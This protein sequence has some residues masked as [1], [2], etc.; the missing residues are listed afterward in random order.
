MD[1][2]Q[3]ESCHRRAVV[4]QNDASC[5]SSSRRPLLAE[6]Y[7]SYS[8]A[9]S[10]RKVEA[11]ADRISSMK[12]SVAPP[13]ASCCPATRRSREVFSIRQT[14]TST[15]CI[16][17]RRA[18]SQDPRTASLFLLCALEEAWSGGSSLWRAARQILF[19]TVL[20]WP[21]LN[22]SV[23]GSIVPSGGRLQGLGALPLMGCA[24]RQFA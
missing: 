9:Q 11:E 16:S 22:V 12:P 21:S 2:R 20:I 8:E 17:L 3:G 23:A 6:R 7:T 14:A 24:V 13:A 4:A 15:R 19:D 1:G 18:S 10:R 5:S